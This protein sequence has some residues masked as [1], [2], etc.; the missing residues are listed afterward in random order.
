MDYARKDRLAAWCEVYGKA[1][2]RQDIEPAGES[3]LLADVVIRQLPGLITMKGSRFEATYTRRKSQVDSDNLFVTITL[4]GTF[5]ARQLGREA[6]MQTGDAFVGTGAEPLVSIVSPGECRVL[7]LSVPCSMIASAVPGLDAMYGRVIPAANPALQMLT[8]YVGVLED[9][10]VSAVSELQ[11]A[12]V[13]H[14]QELLTLALGAT[15]DATVTARLGGGR[16]ARLREIKA[17]IER[18]IGREEISVGAIAAR[19]RLPVRYVQRLF[20][21]EGASFTEYVLGR[22]LAR[23]YSLLTDRRFA[24]LPISA[25]ALEVGFGNQPYFNRSFRGQYGASPSEVRA[26]Q[27]GISGA[28]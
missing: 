28:N 19:H 27:A 14:A 13:R 11:A 5:A 18:A 7:T 17:D 24:D 21:A 25:I 10:D 12:S 6:F 1:M 4:A 15:R 8:R 26:G 3:D 22:R 9:P 20:E 23:A 2:C 16:A